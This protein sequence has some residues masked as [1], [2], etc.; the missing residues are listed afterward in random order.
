ML[1][2][3]L[4]LAFLCSAISFGLFKLRR[5]Q[6][7][8]R[9]QDPEHG[10]SGDDD[11][12]ESDS[13][14]DGCISKEKE[15]V[16]SL[17]SLESIIESNDLKENCIQQLEI[18]SLV[19]KT[20]LPLDPDCSCERG[21]YD[22]V[23]IMNNYV[24]NAQNETLIGFGSVANHVADRSVGSVVSDFESQ[25]S[26]R[27][28]EIVSVNEDI[29]FLEDQVRT[30]SK[31]VECKDAIKKELEKAKN[32]MLWEMTMELDE[33]KEELHHQVGEL[34]SEL[35][36][37]ETKLHEL[38][39]ETDDKTQLKSELA[40]L[41][42]EVKDL[43]DL[44]QNLQKRFCDDKQLE[45]LRCVNILLDHELEEHQQ[46]SQK[47]GSIHRS[48]SLRSQDAKDLNLKIMSKMK[49]YGSSKEPSDC[50]NSSSYPDLMKI[51]VHDYEK[52]T[53]KELFMREDV[54]DANQALLQFITR[55]G[56][57][58]YSCNLEDIWHG[59]SAL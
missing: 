53:L 58:R 39:G 31:H 10:N 35:T 7:Q 37:A 51:V 43:S 46:R 45:Y 28:M 17:N 42:R 16:S 25:I 5:I 32:Q 40:V 57:A 12:T 59:R 50:I 33:K 18:T 49:K 2:G 29:L 4:A 24:P 34:K 1:V 41:R 56:Q 47:V 48:S 54:E 21:A 19:Q 44:F 22:E 9:F 26:E 38:M 55:E 15:E 30:L 27:S 3:R 13:H 20:Y 14:A 36:E 23:D 11:N 8:F 52:S 6:V